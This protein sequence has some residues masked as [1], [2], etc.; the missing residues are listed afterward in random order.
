MVRTGEE[1]VSSGG[2]LLLIADHMPFPGAAADLA[3]AFGILFSNS[4][5]GEVGGD[6]RILVF[7]GSDGSLADHPITRGRNPTEH[8]Q[9]VMTFTGQAFRTEVETSPLLILPRG[10]E[11]LLPVTATGYYT[12]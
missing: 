5:A 2:S 4:Y 11:L 9:S 12:N 8:V 1:W 10:T 3:G 7:Q 6:S